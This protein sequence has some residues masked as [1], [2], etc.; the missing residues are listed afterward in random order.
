MVMSRM[1]PENNI[2][3]ILEGFSLSNTE[4]KLIVVG[5][6]NTPFG[7]KMV[8]KFATDPR[9]YF[10]GNVF[11][12]AILHSLK[13]FCSIYFHG[14][15]AGGTNP[16]LLE[17]MASRALIAAHN[18]EFNRAVLGE[19]ALYFSSAKEVSVFSAFNIEAKADTMKMANFR[20]INEQHNWQKII[21]RYDGFIRDCYNQRHK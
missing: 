7:A 14:H 15:S 1:E 18:N 19:D 8:K 9:I 20:N 4:K 12:A 10:A 21:N 17:A 5:N 2:E 13:Y 11:D 16:S 3:M 6:V